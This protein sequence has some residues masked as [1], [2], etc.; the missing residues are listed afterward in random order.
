MN[1]LPHRLWGGRG[2]CSRRGSRGT[3]ALVPHHLAHAASCYRV[4]GFK[5]PVSLWSMAEVSEYSNL[6]QATSEG[7][8]V[9]VAGVPVDPLGTSVGGVSHGKPNDR[10]WPTR[11]RSRDV[12]AAFGGLDCNWMAFP[13]SAAGENWLRIRGVAASV[14]AHPTGPWG[15]ILPVHAHQRGVFKTRWSG[16]HPTS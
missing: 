4:S 5:R 15:S 7:R 3:R 2:A 10:I 9:E 14:G 12:L 13:L 11:S 6:Y 1:G 8:L 16:D